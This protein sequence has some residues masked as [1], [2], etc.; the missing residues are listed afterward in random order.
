MST[1]R[2]LGQFVADEKIVEWLSAQIADNHKQSARGATAVAK[3]HRLPMVCST[4]DVTK[5]CCS[6]YVLVRL[7]EGLVVAAELARTGRDTP[8]LRDQL[9]ARAELMEST[10]V[11]EW[12]TPCLFL[13][14]TER[15]TVYA[16]RPTTCAQL[17][18]YSAPQLCVARSNEIKSYT[19]RDEVAAANALEEQFREKLSLR[20]KVGRRYFGVLPRM[21]LVSLEAWD[22]TDFRDYL[23]QLPW[24]TD[25]EW[26]DM[27]TR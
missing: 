17:Y 2:T 1:A 11:A 19:P 16:A 14:A 26:A 23:R 6:S 18:V 9:R 15:C 10:P 21:V 3:Q 24:R 27:V 20:K 12:F 7:Y 22:R 5:A 4:C 13:D 25:E 8:E